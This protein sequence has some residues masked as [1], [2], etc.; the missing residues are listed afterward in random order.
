[1]GVPDMITP[2]SYALSYP[3]HM[4]TRLPPLNIEEIGALNFQK[5]DQERFRCLTLALSAAEEGGTMPAVLNGAN[6]IAVESFLKGEIG[7]L[8][9]PALIERTMEAHNSYPIKDINDVVEADIWARET[10]I[11]ELSQLKSSRL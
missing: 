2:I 7:F 11:R 10:A 9:I 6:E 1:M 3:R 8:Q 4:R 5:P